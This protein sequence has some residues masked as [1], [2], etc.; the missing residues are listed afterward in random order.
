MVDF[1][2]TIPFLIRAGAPQVVGTENSAA[3]R[4]DDSRE[5]VVMLDV[6]TVAAGG[7]LDVQVQTA[8]DDAATR[9]AT[10]PGTGAVWHR[11]GDMDPVVAAGQ[12][13]QRF[14]GYGKWVRLRSVVTV[15]TVTYAA[16]LDRKT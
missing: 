10:T 2:T 11:V 8:D 12:V 1:A 14:V 6:T 4:V 5:L 7:Q 16:R 13:L 3:L 9:T 15:N